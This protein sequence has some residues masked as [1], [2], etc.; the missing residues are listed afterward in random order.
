MKRSCALICLCALGPACGPGPLERAFADAARIPNLASLVLE[1]D[2]VIERE[3]YYDGS[4][5]DTPH[6]VRS[7]TK[8]VTSLLVGIALSRGCLRSLDQTLGDLLGPDAPADP[9]K[10]AISLRDILTMSA[11]F[12]W[13]ELGNPD[14]Y[15]S[16]ALAPD[17]IA[18][19][20][21][22][23]LTTTPGTVFDYNTGTFHLLSVILTESCA[24]TPEF[25]QRSL[26]VPLGIGA[27]QWETDAR[28]IANGGA[29]LQLTTRDLLALGRL[30]LD[31]GRFAGKQVV[32]TAFLADAFASHIATGD[33][34]IYGTP[35]YGYGIWI[36][37][38]G[39]FV[40][41]EGYGGQ[42][43]FV[44]PRSRAVVVAT[45]NWIGLRSSAGTDFDRIFQLIVTRILPAL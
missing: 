11:G 14:V 6:D 20:L 40:V 28:G 2:G 23:P 4:G 17:P 41:A 35:G 36:G 7:V 42:F 30:L 19:T 22:Q 45:A 5:P 37:G 15:N 10:A 33:S 9:A 39:T 24:P 3:Q 32:A 44:A 16:W 43:I 29:G 13:D 26:F 21:A 8:T 25:A 27:R 31:G 34:P 12:K 18:F 38:A 1:R